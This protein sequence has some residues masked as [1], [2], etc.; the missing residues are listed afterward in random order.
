MAFK[1]LP[2]P[3][4]INEQAEVNI[5]TNRLEGV[6]K[7]PA[8]TIV[9]KRLQPGIWS[10]RNGKAHFVAV[11]IIARDEHSVAISGIEP[12]TVILV[13]GPKKKALEEGMRLYL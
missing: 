9:Y 3:F 8:Y 1:V 10:V 11:K 13:P 2:K 5:F 12:Q 6:L 4:S 7:V